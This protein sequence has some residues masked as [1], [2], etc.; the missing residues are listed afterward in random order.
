[1]AMTAFTTASNSTVKKWS[2]TLAVEAMVNSYFSRFMG[3]SANNVLVIQKDLNKAAGDRIRVSLR[4]KMNDYGIEG[5]NIIEGTS[6]EESLTFYTQDIT[7]DQLRKGTKSKGKMSEQRVLYN[8]RVQGR[9][10]L[11]TWWGET[12]DAMCFVYLSGARGIDSTLTLPL[13]W[14]GFAGNAL[15]TPDSAHVVYGGNATGLSDMDSAD[16][17]SVALF[18]VLKS[19]AE[20]TDPMIQPIM[21]NGAKKYVCVLH[22]WQAFDLRTSLSTKDWLVVHTQVD[23]TTSDIY[24]GALGEWAGIVLHSHRNI[25]RFDST[26]GCAAGVTA[27]RAL[28]LGA[29]AGIMAWGQ[30][31]G[32]GRWTWHEELDDRGNALAITSGSIFGV[33]KSRFNSL[34]FGVM[35]VDTYAATPTAG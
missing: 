31:G 32:P 4:M 19:R 28:F 2:N 5:D 9:D 16:K 22:P 26:T 14:S 8:M 1:M 34:D 23:K 7:I 21:Y 3:S 35:A 13:T 25:V 24:T 17:M 33:T 29:Q 15:A 10:A 12:M 18:E 27:A 6:G 11:A 20:T 30:N